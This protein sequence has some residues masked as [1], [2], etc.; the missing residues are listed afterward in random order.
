MLYLN[1]FRFDTTDADEEIEG[2]AN[3]SIS[4]EL[5]E[6]NRP[7]KSSALNDVS[8]I[9]GLSTMPNCT[10]SETSELQAFQAVATCDEHQSCNGG[11]RTPIR[12]RSALSV[13]KMKPTSKENETPL[14]FR[15]SLTDIDPSS[16]I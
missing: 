15:Y 3:N 1:K 6:I 12:E 4:S 5:V 13:N 16:C 2:A 7:L 10:E 11:N 14:S 8:E 9:K